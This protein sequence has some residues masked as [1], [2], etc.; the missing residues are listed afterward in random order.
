MT[1]SLTHVSPRDPRIQYIGRLAFPGAD[2][3]KMGFPGVTIRFAYRGPAPTLAF[4]ATSPFCAFNLTVNGW[5]PVVIRL[6]EGRSELP[7]PSGVAPQDG[8]VVELVR[9]NENWQGLASFHGFELPAGCELVAPPP[10]P[11][12]KLMFIGDSITCGEAI[13]RFPPELDNTSRMANA[14]RSYGMLLGR[15]LG[16]QVHLV[17]CGGRGVM[18][19]WKG[20]GADRDVTAPQFFQRALPDDPAAAW[21]HSA[22]TP[23]AIVICLG[24]NDLNEPIDE[25]VFTAAFTGFLADIRRVHPRAA[26]LFTESPMRSEDPATKDGQTREFQRRCLSNVIAAARAAGDMRVAFAPLHQHAGTPT[27]AHPVAFQHEQMAA[28]L[29]GPLRALVGW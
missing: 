15:A 22:Y 19:N 2:E 3:A 21:D 9:R 6:P 13:D 16:A 23:D 17:S 14:A 4:G 1:A 7:L 27:N 18:R 24:Q 10:P 25:T 11:A 5:D 28:E 12:R 26:V 20:E 29:I 8:W